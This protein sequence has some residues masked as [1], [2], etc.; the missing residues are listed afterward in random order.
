MIGVFRTGSQTRH[1][2]EVGRMQLVLLEY[3]AKLAADGTPLFLGRTHNNKRCFVR[4]VLAVC[5][6]P[7]RARARV[8]RGMV[9]PFRHV[10]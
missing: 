1:V 3:T 2:A 7:V 6:C 10:L 4:G 5:P 9:T 8:A